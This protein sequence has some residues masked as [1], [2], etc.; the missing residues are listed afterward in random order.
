ML[1]SSPL[2]RPNVNK[3]LFRVVRFITQYSIIVAVSFEYIFAPGLGVILPFSFVVQL[4][5]HDFCPLVS[6]H[7]LAELKMF[8]P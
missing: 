1:Q 3:D 7:F 4:I 6:C 5:L 2:R 8:L